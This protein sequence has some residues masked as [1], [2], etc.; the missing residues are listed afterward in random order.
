MKPKDIKALFK[1]PIS[2]H[3]GKFTLKRSYYWGITRSG[4]D[5][6]EPVV[7]EKVPDAVVVGWGNHYHGFVGGAKSGSAQDSY[8]WIS[9]T[10]PGIA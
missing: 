5:V 7:R 8:Y 6:L 2:Y 10:V 4:L 3:K 9:F 1:G